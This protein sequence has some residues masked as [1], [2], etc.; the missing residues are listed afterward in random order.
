MSFKKELQKR[1]PASAFKHIKTITEGTET[2]LVEFA[3]G[4]DGQNFTYDFS[5]DY[6]RVITRE[7]D[8]V[9]EVYLYGFIGQDFWW[10]DEEKRK[11]SITD[12]EFVK[13]I[14]EL[15]K[16][17]ER[18]D[19]HINSPGGNVYHGDA[20][21]TAIRNSKA[22]IHTYNDGMCASMGFDIWLAGHERHTSINAKAMCHATASVEFGTAAD[23]RAAAEKLDLFD[24]AQVNTFVAV[25]GLAE[26]EVRSMFYDD[27]RDHWLT[28]DRMLELNLVKE[29]ED[30]EV[31]EV[32]VE[33]RSAKDLILEV[34]K[35]EIQKEELTEEQMIAKL[36]EK[37]GDRL[38][39]EIKET[40]P[41][42]ELDE[43]EQV[44][45]EKGISLE[46][47]KVRMAMQ[48]KRALA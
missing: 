26:N 44:P 19:I 8:D 21:I 2:L 5:K 18:I 37:Y 31:K 39:L 22:E 15:E 4:E 43:E 14:R 25:T 48:R 42:A 12:M 3:I 1:L 46:M 13:T 41:D 30:Y 11:E 40:H 7:T 27:Y 6:F 33:E 35:V 17:Y 45:E 47:A 24:T 28:A 29:I 38:T 16:D 36:Q 34:T 10:A 23:M 20:I 9:A 32:E